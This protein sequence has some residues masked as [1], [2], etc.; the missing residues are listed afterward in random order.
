MPRNY[1]RSMKL[2][3]ANLFDLWQIAMLYLLEGFQRR[4]VFAFLHLEL[5]LFVG[6]KNGQSR[7]QFQDDLKIAIK[8]CN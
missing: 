8:Y 6:D 5:Q 2:L 7:M 1:P 4:V 3:H